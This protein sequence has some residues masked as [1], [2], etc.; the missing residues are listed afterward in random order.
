[1]F[2]TAAAPNKRSLGA[3]NG[4]TATVVAIQRTVGSPAAASL[5][6]FSLANNV[7]GLGGNFTYIVLLL[8]VGVGIVVPVQLPR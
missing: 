5:F 8:V 1:M 3:T 6:A 2:L 4:Q 7:L